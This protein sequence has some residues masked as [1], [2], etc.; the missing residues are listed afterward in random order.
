MRSSKHLSSTA[1]TKNTYIILVRQSENLQNSWEYYQ[2]SE[3]ETKNIPKKF[4]YWRMKGFDT[5]LNRDQWGA[6]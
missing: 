3:N 5:G 2:D 4:L 6:I 1:D